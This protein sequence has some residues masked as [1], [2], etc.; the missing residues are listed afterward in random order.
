MASMARSMSL[1]VSKA[2]ARSSFFCSL[3]QHSEMVSPLKGGGSK[4][5]APGIRI[6]CPPRALLACPI[7]FD[8]LAFL[9]LDPPCKRVVEAD[10][11]SPPAFGPSS[12]RTSDALLGIDR[13]GVSGF[14][15]EIFPFDP[16]DFF[17][18][19]VLRPLC[20]GQS[21]ENEDTHQKIIDRTF[22]RL[23]RTFILINE[24]ACIPSTSKRVSRRH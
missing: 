9:I 8:L 1:F 21:S 12:N 15:A 11:T 2:S 7:P 4:F 24:Q 18:D 20:C 14:S 23:D 13:D 17:M 16:R 6:R 19:P 10:P 3:W 22:I 5:R